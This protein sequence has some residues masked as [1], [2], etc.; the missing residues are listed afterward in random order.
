MFPHPQPLTLFAHPAP[1]HQPPQD[2]SIPTHIN[3]IV[4]RNYVKVEPGRRVVPT[5]L[6]VTLIKG[7]GGRL[8]GGGLVAGVVSAVQLGLQG[9]G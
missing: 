8:G 4:E 2:A 9:R 7:C 1:L 5:E 6:G 3:N